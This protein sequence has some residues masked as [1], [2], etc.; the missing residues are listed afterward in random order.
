MSEALETAQKDKFELELER[1]T[2]ILQS[3]QANNG[4]NS[5]LNCEKIFEC[6][7]RKNYV[8]AVY[9]SMSKGDS[10]GFDF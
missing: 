5:C 1:Q 8:D 4:L 7:T 10:G 6:E 3:C 9:F 2:Q